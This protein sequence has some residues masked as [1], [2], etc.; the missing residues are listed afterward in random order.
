MPE[1]Q[2]EVAENTESKTTEVA[3]D[4]QEAQADQEQSG[5]EEKVFTDSFGNKYTADEFQDK[6]N[7]IQG[8]F[9]QKAQEASVYQ[10]ELDA[11][12]KQSQS[13]ARKSV[14]E[15]DSLKD[16]PQDVKEAIISVVQPEIEKVLLKQKQEEQQREDDMRFKRELDELEKEFDGK[17]GK[18]KFDRNLVLKAMKDPN[19]RIFDP[20]AKFWDMHK[21]TFNDIIV[22]EALKKQKGGIKTEDT[23]GDHSKPE[24]HTPKNWGEA[25]K[26]ALARF[27]S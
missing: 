10:K 18:P 12:K 25:R 13:D 2:V 24:P 21:D 20:R 14:N 26:A 16:V 27:I 1:D 3:E 6:F 11:I 5:E 17:N 7:E 19:N 8:S 22:R 23:K 15:N 9:T 4:N